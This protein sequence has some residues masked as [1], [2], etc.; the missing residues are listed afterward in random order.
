MKLFL[1]ETQ[2]NYILNESTNDSILIVGDSHS[3]PGSF[4][5][6]G[7]LSSQMPNVDNISEGGK[8]TSWMLS[9]LKSALSSKKYDKVIIW[10]GYNDAF[11]EVPTSS[12]IS[13]IQQMVDLVNNQGGKAYVIV[14]HNTK[15]FAKKGGYK[16][17]KYA[18]P[19]E[20]DEMREKY[21]K[22]QEELPNSISNATII[23]EFDLDNSYTKDNVH[24]NSS[25]H[26][27]ILNKVLPYIN[28][29][30]GKSKKSNNDVDEGFLKKE[31]NFDVIPDGKNNYRSA[32]IPI[33]FKGEDLYDKIVDKYGIKKIIRLNGDGGDSKDKSS[34][35]S[36][37]IDSERKFAEQKGV[38]FYKLSAT[39]D[40][41][42]INSLLSGG[43]VLIHCAHGADRTGGTVGGYLYK[44]GWG[45][46][47]EI[48]DY[49]TSYNSWNGLVKNNLEKFE[50]GGYFRLS[51]K[52][53][54]SSLDDA[55]S[56][57][58]QP[59]KQKKSAIKMSE[60][61][62][63]LTPEKKVVS[64]L[65]K[66]YKK[67]T[68]LRYDESKINQFN[69]DIYDLQFALQ[70]LGFYPDK[71]D[72]KFTPLTR[73]AIARFQKSIGNKGTGNYK[74]N[75]IK[76]LFAKLKENSFIKKG[77]TPIVGDNDLKQNINV[78]ANYSVGEIPIKWT[79]KYPSYD[80]MEKR[81]KE[82]LGES[83][84]NKFIS[85]CNS[86]GISKPIV[87]KHL[88]SESA[89][90]DDIISCKKLSSAGAMGLAQ[91]MPGTWPSYGKGSP[92]NPND[93]VK[94]YVKFMDV[95]IKR[96]NG[97]LDIAIASYNSGPNYRVYK[98]AADNNTPFQNIKRG[99][100]NGGY[101][102]S[103]YHYTMR[104]LTG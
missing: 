34:H 36:T 91:F 68:I 17:T 37:S 74:S 7:K 6:A 92:C 1:S 46:T 8:R 55:V 77:H 78:K 49:T 94:A 35:P 27:F 80:N 99:T 3:V 52:F 82:I 21:I 100:Q 90:R 14:G 2:I 84:Y 59:K 63:E 98:Q 87:L 31:F 79:Y 32:Q 73:K 45:N 70:F 75:E 83:E 16:G 18:T 28:E 26:D 76:P 9:Q 95:L 38:E 11:S 51:Q 64:G 42:K 30:S 89:Y 25:A 96:F 10:G 40:Q 69:Q 66:F 72:G 19:Q 23:P 65:K 53:G 97:R 60:K 33:N 54:V 20:M 47:K 93:A 24:G 88:Y 13:N 56:L 29:S 81:L 41:D 48:W 5:W 62:S 44:N 15:T 43:N 57:S 12:I 104:I 85:D 71:I 39:R 102:S 86:I 103:T 61:S 50:S 4:T 67:N 22:F 58:G 101:P